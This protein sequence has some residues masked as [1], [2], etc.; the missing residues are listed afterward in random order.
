MWVNSKVASEILNVTNRALQK[1]TSIAFK[2]GKKICSIK[3]N[4]L[5]FIY[6]EG[7]GGNSGKVLQIWIDKNLTKDALK[8]G[9][10]DVGS[11]ALHITSS[12]FKHETELIKDKKIDIKI[13]DLENMT[14]VQ[15]VNELNS[16]P[17]GFKKRLCHNK[18]LIN[19]HF[20]RGVSELP[21]KLLFAVIYTHLEFRYEM[22]HTITS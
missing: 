11:S 14:K 2:K 12:D 5:N 7:R 21:Y 19:S 13:E 10:L 4:I 16:C 18:Q 15:A 17:L 6:I 1:A 20:Y 9:R 22:S 3:S 8:N